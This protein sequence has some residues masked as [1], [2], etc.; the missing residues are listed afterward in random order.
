MGP[1]TF[2]QE[3][4]TNLNEQVLDLNLSLSLT[5][6][7]P[8]EA[9]HKTGYLKSSLLSPSKPSLNMDAQAHTH[10]EDFTGQSST[11][12]IV[13]KKLPIITF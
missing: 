7:V 3:S 1:L 9:Q 6:L 2:K 12:K 13:N 11:G 8:V 10:T 5:L 4:L